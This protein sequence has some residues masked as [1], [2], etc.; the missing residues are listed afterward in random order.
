VK[1]IAAALV[2]FALAGCGSST[3]RTGEPN[4]PSPQPG[5]VTPPG[6]PEPTGIIYRPIQN[7]AYTLE[8][9]DSLFLQLPGGANQQQLIDRTAF[10]SVTLVPDTGGYQATIVLD[11]LHAVANGA[12][13]SLDSLVPAWGTR[14][15]GRL[16]SSGD[17]SA[18]KADRSTTL[19]DQVGST[20]RSLFPGLPNGGVRAGM[21]WTDTTDVPIRADAFD[22]S[23]RGVT[24][25]RSLDSDEPRAKNAIKLESTGSYERKGKGVQFEQQLEMSGAGSRTGVHYF[26]QDGVLISARGSDAGNMTITVPAV[27]QTV[28]VKQAGSYTITSRGQ[29]RR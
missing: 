3:A 1:H 26:G 14:W 12:P 18:L 23:E 27:G 8:R 15:T 16:S 10:V 2:L 4:S 28:P 7:A 9:H 29:P 21:Q 19:G 25:Y 17:L 6:A 13:A 24:H 20:L 5:P 22:A 11:S